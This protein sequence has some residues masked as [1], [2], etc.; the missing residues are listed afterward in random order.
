MA[1][2]IISKTKEKGI[3]GQFKSVMNWKITISDGIAL[4]LIIFLLLTIFPRRL[5]F[6]ETLSNLLSWIL[7]PSLPLVV[8]YMVKR[9]WI[10]SALWGVS[11][12]TFVFLF[13]GLFLPNIGP[14]HVCDSDGP[15]ACRHLKVMS[16]NLLAERDGD[17][18][19]QLEMMRNSGADIIA[20]QEVGKSNV[21]AVDQGM[22]ELY[23]YRYLFPMSVAGTGILSKYPI[24][25]QEAFQIT[26]GA[27]YHTKAVIDVDGD[28]LTVYSVHPPP[29]V[30]YK[31]KNTRRREISKL[32]EMASGNGPTIMMGDFNATDQ[33]SDYKPLARSG[34][35]DAFRVAGWGFGPTWPVK[36]PSVGRF[37]PLVRIDYVWVSDD[38]EV[39]SARTGP[40]TNS[41]HLPV[42]VEVSY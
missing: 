30:T 33:S 38:F 21:E 12:L 14:S 34:L 6:V 24:E 35:H 4:L 19:P 2:V 39:L 23:P 11:A 1:R 25:S 26:P 9:R 7:L 13:G 22:A 17:Y 18:R 37:L 8:F 15:N 36:L 29:P 28:T 40:R 10:S 42:F 3:T 20:L 16:F 5:W 27:L 31:Y 41:D 32:V